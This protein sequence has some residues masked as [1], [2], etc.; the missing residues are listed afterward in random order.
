MFFRHRVWRVSPK[1]YQFLLLPPPPRQKIISRT[2]P[3]HS[4]D[5]RMTTVTYNKT[6]TTE[7]VDIILRN[8]LVTHFTIVWFRNPLT[9]I[10]VSF[11]NESDLIRK[12][13]LRLNTYWSFTITTHHF[14]SPYFLLVRSCVTWQSGIRLNPMRN[15]QYFQLILRTS[16]RQRVSFECHQTLPW[17]WW[18]TSQRTKEMSH[19]H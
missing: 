10:W 8:D 9:G 16:G 19:C 4:L 6:T 18:H 17:S 5:Q 13:S 12:V 11:L 1:V 15:F 3:S 2:Y 7:T 14:F